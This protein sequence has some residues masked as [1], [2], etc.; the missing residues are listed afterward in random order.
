MKKITYN[1]TLFQRTVLSTW[2]MFSPNGVRYVALPMCQASTVLQGVRAPS[3]VS[4]LSYI[5]YTPPFYM[6]I[7][8]FLIFTAT[9]IILFCNLAFLTA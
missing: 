8:P 7:Y 5:W 9:G 6:H 1:F 3:H 2:L 4:L